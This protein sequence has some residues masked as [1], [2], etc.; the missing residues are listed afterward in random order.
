M[1]FYHEL[2]DLKTFTNMLALDGP[3]IYLQIMDLV[4]KKKW[5]GDA[6]FAFIHPCLQKYFKVKT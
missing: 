1:N 6:L 4:F 5:L 2:Y 3:F